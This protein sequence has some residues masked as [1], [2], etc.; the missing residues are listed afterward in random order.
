M[1]APPNSQELVSYNAQKPHNVR[2]LKFVIAFAI[3]LLI[4]GVANYFKLFTRTPTPQKNVATVNKSTTPSPIPE[5]KYDA[6]KAKMLLTQYIKDAIKPE[7]LPDNIEVKQGLSPTGALQK[8][9]YQ[10][11]SIFNT[12][13]GIISAVMHYKIDSNDINDYYIY[14]KSKSID[15]A[16]LTAASTSALISTY[17]KNAP[18]EIS[19]KPA[20]NNSYCENFK[21]TSNA[22][23]G[24]GILKANNSND[25]IWLFNCF[26]SNKSKNYENAKSCLAF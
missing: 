9:N 15:K 4:L 22:K 2:P 17:F 6:E 20:Q 24:Y 26:I 12:K 25:E 8:L 1:E 23:T 19:C 21:T 14:I 18:S 3:L 16:S 7:Y 11:G 5:F 13:N 10:F